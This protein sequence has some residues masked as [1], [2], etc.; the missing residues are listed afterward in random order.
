MKKFLIVL[1]FFSLLLIG[2]D[3]KEEIVKNDYLMFKS[4]LLSNDKFMDSQDINF[5]IVVKIDRI[6]EEEI[7]YE[8]IISNPS[9]NMYKIKALLVHNYYTEDIFPSIGI[10]DDE[11]DYLKGSSNELILKGYIKTDKDIDNLDLEL[12]L[13]F[14]Y[15]DDFGNRKD[16]YYK[17]TK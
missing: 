8:M 2:C 11:V 14:S 10:L 13:Y 16:I 17:T 4:K 5:S 15:I 3:N 9:F 12:K 6:N 7:S 1:L